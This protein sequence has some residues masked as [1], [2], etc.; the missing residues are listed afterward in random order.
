MRLRAS[1]ELLGAPRI[2]DQENMLHAPR[3]VWDCIAPMCRMRHHK[4]YRGIADNAHDLHGFCPSHDASD[5]RM[6]GFFSV[7][8]VFKFFSLCQA[9]L[10]SDI[11]LSLPSCSC[12]VRFNAIP[13]A[14]SSRHSFGS[15]PSS[16]LPPRLSSSF[17]S[18]RPAA[19]DK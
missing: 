7:H 19:S 15:V 9:W 18:H 2:T 6:D 1:V 13:F 11:F 14:R 8:N 3:A 17:Q 10:F 16:L 5:K 12:F 4:A